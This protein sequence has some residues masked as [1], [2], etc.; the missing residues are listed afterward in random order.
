MCLAIILLHGFSL[1]FALFVVI[2]W[3]FAQKPPGGHEDAA[4]RRIRSDLITG[5]CYELPGGPCISAG[6]R[7]AVLGFLCCLA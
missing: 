5:L 4:R 3:V 2:S 6:R 1:A 7:E